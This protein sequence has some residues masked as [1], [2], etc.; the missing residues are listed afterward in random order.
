M[1]RNGS[2]RGILTHEQCYLIR[3]VRRNQASACV[4]RRQQHLCYSVGPCGAFSPM[5]YDIALDVQ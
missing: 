3:G 1:L 2:L 5:S 4:R